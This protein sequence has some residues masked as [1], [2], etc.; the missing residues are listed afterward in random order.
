MHGRIPR[1]VLVAPIVAALA[2]TVTA[3]RPAALG[4]AET[5]ALKSISSRLDGAVSTVLIEASEPVA[6]L[7]SQPDPLTVLVDLRNVNAA[8]LD[9]RPI[10]DLLAPVSGVGV[11]RATAPDGSPVA[12]VRVRL[13]RAARHRVRS[14][15][16]MILVEFD[17]DGGRP[18]PR[19]SR[20]ARQRRRSPP[21]P[22]ASTTAAKAAGCRGA[23]SAAAATQLRSVRYAEDRRPATR[24]PS[25][26]TARCVASKVEEAKDLPARVL[27]D[28]DGV[29]AGS[30]PAVTNVKNDDIDRVRVAT[31]SREPLITRVVIDLA[32]KLPYTVEADR[33][34]PARAVQQRAV[35]ATAA[36]CAPAR[37][38]PTPDEPP[39]AATPAPTRRRRRAAAA[40][41]R[42]AGAR[43]RAR[44][45]APPMLPR[46]DAR[47][48]APSVSQA[49]LP[50]P[51]PASLG[52]AQAQPTLP[53]RCSRRR[54]R[55]GSA[56]SR[57]TR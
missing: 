47:R 8:A 41:R 24:S 13:D 37:R 38:P 2:V 14:A 55:Q 48:A 21:A 42:R 18:V 57:A 29:A 1:L 16:N 11:E 44:A 34:G 23:R 43:R 15:R 54:T 12:R 9:G 28:F 22:A 53:A 20:P 6:Y 45:P 46:R 5:P 10:A 4:G 7:T 26:A 51:T 36:R 32:R 17:R 52:A 40:G 25:P 35:D 31:N 56:S 3:S 19:P 27:L 50:V 49:P 39:V 30:A 33:R